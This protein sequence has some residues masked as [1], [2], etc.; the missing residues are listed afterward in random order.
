MSEFE[1]FMEREDRWG[2]NMKTLW[3]SLNICPIVTRVRLQHH[4]VEELDSISH[5][6]IW[7]DAQKPHQDMTYLLVWV[8]NTPDTKTY[9]LTLVWVSLF[10]TR[11][12][13]MVEALEIL[14][15]FAFEGS[16]WPYTLIQLYEGANHTP[17]P[18]NKHLG[19]LPQEKTESPSGQ[20]SQ[21]KI[22][23]LLSARPLVV[24]PM[25]LNGGDQ[26]VTVKLSVPLHTGSSVTTDKH[27]YIEV[28]IP[29]PTMEEKDCNTP[30]QIGQPD[31]LTV[32]IPKTLWKPRITLSAEVHELPVRGMTDNYDWELEHSVT[33][34]HAI[35]VEHP[36][37]KG[38]RN[39]YYPW[40]HPHRQVLKGRRP[41]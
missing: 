8:D 25:E 18:E 27:S 6:K 26:A 2:N 9:G 31:V 36:H 37:S 5:L 4:M 12:S 20:V 24:F 11:I 7:G 13:S 33:A 34:V 41:L 14:T 39:L 38:R 35:Q 40:K 10:Q 22:H 29:L 15:T 32:T 23:Q 21:L 17:L 19:V 16:D 1:F 30:P 3:G 28:N